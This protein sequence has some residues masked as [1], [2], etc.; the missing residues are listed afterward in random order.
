MAMSATARHLCGFVCLARR[1]WAIPEEGREYAGR[2]EP[3]RGQE[4]EAL[5]VVASDVRRRPVEGILGF[6]QHRGGRGGEGVVCSR[7]SSWVLGL[8]SWGGSCAKAL[9]AWGVPGAA[10][11][12]VSDDGFH[13]PS[14]KCHPGAG[15]GADAG[16]P[17]SFN[18]CSALHQGPTMAISAAHALGPALN[19]VLA[20]FSS[21]PL[22]LLT[23]HRKSAA[24]SRLFGI[25]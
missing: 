5:D 1:M 4:Y 19:V 17:R 15:A 18:K 7:L 21:L 14:V 16:V 2:L 24:L 25:P 6:G 22:A 8:G 3:A 23:V 11:A 9:E 20:L 12:Q 13:K 10:L